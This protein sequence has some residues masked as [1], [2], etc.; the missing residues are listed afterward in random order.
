MKAER[1][2]RDVELGQRGQTLAPRVSLGELVGEDL[3]Y[4]LDLSAKDGPTAA[5]HEGEG[6]SRPQAG[7]PMRPK[8]LRLL[9]VSD[10]V[11]ERTLEEQEHGLALLD[12]GKDGRDGVVPFHGPPGKVIAVVVGCEL[13]EPRE[14][15]SELG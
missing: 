5:R 15:Q 1:R 11:V 10:G 3:V 6:V 7:A 13:R 12:A 2:Q 14:G 4:G 9:A 8:R